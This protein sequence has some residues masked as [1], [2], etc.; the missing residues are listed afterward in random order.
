MSTDIAFHRCSNFRLERTYRTNAN[1]VTLAIE[2]DGQ[3]TEITL[4]ELPK[5]I[6][7]KFEA[8]RDAETSDYVDTEKRAAFEQP[9]DDWRAAWHGIVNAV[10]DK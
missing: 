3:T 4:Y 7:D 2:H 6:T 10:P 9:T 8:F 5:E 1:S